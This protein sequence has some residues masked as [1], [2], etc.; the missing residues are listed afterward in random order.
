MA[1]DQIRERSVARRVSSR[2]RDIGGA[3]PARGGSRRA[4]LLRTAP[5]MLAVPL[6]WGL[7]SGNLADVVALA[8]GLAVIYLGT[9]LV[10]S[11]LAKEADYETRELAKAPRP[12]CKLLGAIAI[13]I[14]VLV[15]SLGATG[16]GLPLSLLLAAVAGAGCLMAYGMDPTRDKG[17]APELARRAGV[18]TEQVIEAVTEAEAKLREIERLAGGLHNR[19]L[20]DRL[21]RIVAQAR[22]VLAQIEKDPSDLRRARRFLVTYL[23]GTRDVVRK[24]TDQQQDLAETELAANFRHVLETVERVFTE[25]EQV[26]KRNETMDLEVQIEVL[27]TQLEREGVA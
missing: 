20:T 22:V 2:D 25:Q 9:G 17:L 10:E 1:E 11:G 26:L 24:Y 4:W 14:G 12:P 3:P 19:E 18:K 21:G 15:S 6:V 16:A 23:D 5:I 27:R 8:V 7:V 13:G